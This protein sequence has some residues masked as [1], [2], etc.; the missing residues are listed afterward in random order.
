MLFRP[1]DGSSIFLR[2]ACSYR[3][4][5]FLSWR[6]RQ[7]AP[8]ILCLQPWPLPFTCTVCRE[9]PM[10]VN[11]KLVSPEHWLELRW[12]HLAVFWTLPAFKME[13]QISSL[14]FLSGTYTASPSAPLRCDR[15]VRGFCCDS[16]VQISNSQP[17]R[18]HCCWRWVSSGDV[19][20]GTLL[21]RRTVAVSCGVAAQRNYPGVFTDSHRHQQSPSWRPD[22]T[23]TL[24]PGS[25]CFWG[26][27]STASSVGT[28]CVR[29]KRNHQHTIHYSI[30]V[31][32]NCETS[33]NINITKFR[34][35]FT[36]QHLQHDSNEITQNNLKTYKSIQYIVKEI[37]TLWKHQIH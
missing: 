13:E 26:A 36:R 23:V 12:R 29:T 15:V 37:Q 22:N 18:C 16:D 35:N 2:Q 19:V 8:C 10:Y 9:C 4:N 27:V 7:Q 17:H 30:E 24:L 28:Q 25:A 33:T 11:V 6:L 32:G 1:E 21:R 3:L 14:A 20:G 5:T 31:R 34:F